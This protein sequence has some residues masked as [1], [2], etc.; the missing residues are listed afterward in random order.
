VNGGLRI[1]STSNNFFIGTAGTGFTNLM[2]SQ[3]NSLA[4]NTGGRSAVLSTSNGLE[5]TDT[6][7]NT[8]SGLTQSQLIMTNTANPADD[9]T[10]TFTPT[11]AGFVRINTGNQQSF[12]FDNDGASGG[13]IDYTNTIGSNGMLIRSNQSVSLE[14]TTGL[15][16]LT[17]LPTSV[18]GLP[19]GALWNNSGVLSIA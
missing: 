14:S 15:F 18:G 3:V 9:L 12:S 5:L 16:F 17:N 1:P 4:D 11:G 6:P 19:T 2:S 8:F 10:A 13:T 7:N